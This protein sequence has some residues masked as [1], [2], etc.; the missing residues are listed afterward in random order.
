MP[1]SLSLW[2]SGLFFI[3]P[4]KNQPSHTPPS[5]SLPT[6][7]ACLRLPA[8]TGRADFPQMVGPR[9]STQHA[10]RAVTAVP[11]RSVYRRAPVATEDVS[12]ISCEW[13][14]RSWKSDPEYRKSAVCD[15][16]L[17]FDLPCKESRNLI[18]TPGTL[19]L[20]I[21]RPDHFQLILALDILA[22]DIYF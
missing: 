9:I 19:S 18:R 20:P 5:S 21:D 22:L 16:F 17:P 7:Q 14:P 6:P 15:Y 13:Q 1:Y 2:Y 3:Q 12:T 11:D 4:T 10:F 8:A